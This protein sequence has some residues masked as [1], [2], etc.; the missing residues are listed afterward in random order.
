MDSRWIN[1]FRL[2]MML[3]LVIVASLMIA[4]TFKFTKND[5]KEKF[6]TE[7]QALADQVIDT[8]HSSASNQL[9]AM[10]A[11]SVSYT[12]YA[13]TSGNTFPNVTLPHY[14]IKG[15]NTRIISHGFITHFFPVVTDE[16]RRGWEEYATQTKGHQMEAFLSQTKLSAAQD[17]KYG[18]DPMP[19]GA[20]AGGRALMTQEVD[21]ISLPQLQE[22]Y[23]GL[24]DSRHLQ[25]DLQGGDNP[26]T[27]PFSPVI[28]DDNGNEEL[29][30]MGPYLPLWQ[31]TPTIPFPG[32]LTLNCLRFP[33][34]DEGLK[35][36]LE[37]GKAY[38]HSGVVND[39]FF[40]LYLPRSQYRHK[41]ETVLLD[42][43]TPI[44]YPV[45]DSFDL[46][47][48]KQVGLL[49]SNIYWRL[50]FH[51]ILPEN[52]AGVIVVLKNTDE[53]VFSYRIDGSEASFLGAEDLHDSKYNSL[54]VKADVAAYLTA[55]AG[56]ETRGYTAVD[57]NEDG[58]RYYLYV[59]PSDDLKDQ[60]ETNKPAV[61]ASVVALAFVITSAMFLLYDYVVSRRQ[62]EMM[63]Q[64]KLTNVEKETGGMTP[65]E[66]E[67]GMMTL[68]EEEGKDVNVKSATSPIDEA[69]AE[70]N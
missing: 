16:D 58:V 39:Q 23:L 14:E 59:Y 10:D 57:I 47:T 54:Q 36:T 37:S 65:P 60:F 70:F 53:Q 44:A 28:V 4:G 51:D 43:A 25:R 15:A 34:L 40:N 38:I 62:K 1:Y 24:G 69:T 13:L 7:F 20:G 46:Q 21:E 55:Q 52:T 22:A 30:G 31:S 8:F 45:F 32:L 27:R 61:Y 11:L 56:P 2:L 68:P 50:Y 64:I 12:S 67:T 3:I 48:R 19:V 29:E 17:V 66:E 5:E 18:Y 33:L 42:A 41:N 6:E 26:V 35:N 63:A 9:A 49:S